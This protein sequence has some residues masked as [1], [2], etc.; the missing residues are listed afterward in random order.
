MQNDYDVDRINLSVCFKDI[1]I[2]LFVYI[3]TDTEEEK[4]T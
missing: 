3:S 1:F 2:Y 4:K